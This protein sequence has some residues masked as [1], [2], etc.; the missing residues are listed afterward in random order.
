[1]K[2]G[3]SDK[4]KKMLG[5]SE[6]ASEDKRGER[7]IKRGIERMGVQQMLYVMSH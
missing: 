6:R 4:Q 1:M 7:Q 3:G 5:A 2:N